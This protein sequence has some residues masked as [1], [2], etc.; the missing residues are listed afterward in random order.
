MQHIR[1]IL[2]FER[3]DIL[4]TRW[5]GNVDSVFPDFANEPRNAW[6]GLST[7]WFCPF[8][9]HGKQY[10]L[11]LVILNPYNLSL[12]MCMKS[13]TMFITVLVSSSR[14]SNDKLDVYLQSWIRDLVYLW[15]T[16]MQTYDVSRNQNFTMRPAVLW[17]ISDYPMYSMLSR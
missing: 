14:N 2:L 3:C 6:L 4:Q 15:E 17:T 11:W 10:S 8:G 7:N 5:L 13:Q 9:M 1:R 16:G 12:L